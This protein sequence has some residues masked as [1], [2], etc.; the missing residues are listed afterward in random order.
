MKTFVF[1][2]LLLL[3]ASC[4][5]MEQDVKGDPVPVNQN[6]CE[7]EPPGTPKATA[8]FFI[9]K[10]EQAKV[11]TFGWHT[12]KAKVNIH[13]D[14]R[15][16]L[17][18]FVNPQPGKTERYIRHHLLSFRV[19]E[20]YLDGGYIKPGEQYVQLRCMKENVVAE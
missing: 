20:L 2:F 18:Q 12:V 1:F 5:Q 16:D 10:E 11:K 19:K 9:D 3:A 7:V 6:R 15:V 8:I 17:I 13:K 14:G 4:R